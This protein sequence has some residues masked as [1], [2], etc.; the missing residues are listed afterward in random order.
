MPAYSI[1]DIKI[2]SGVSE[3]NGTFKAFLDYPIN[4]YYN[5]TGTNSHAGDLAGADTWGQIAWHSSFHSN[6]NQFRTHDQN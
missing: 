3:E 4:I 1:Q 5:V 6:T 2:N